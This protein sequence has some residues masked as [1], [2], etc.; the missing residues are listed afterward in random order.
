MTPAF[1]RTFKG[2]KETNSHTNDPEQC[3]KALE[4]LGKVLS[5]N[6]TVGTAGPSKAFVH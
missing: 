3:V 5:T 4:E 1:N 2:I 6:L